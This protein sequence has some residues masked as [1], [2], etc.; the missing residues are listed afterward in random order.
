LLFFAGSRTEVPVS[1]PIAQV[2]K[3]AATAMPDPPLEAP[4]SRSVS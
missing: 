4:G 1:S 2:T 3:L